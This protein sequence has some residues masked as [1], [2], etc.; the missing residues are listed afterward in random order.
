MNSPKKYVPQSIMVVFLLIMMAV[1]YSINIPIAGL[2]NDSLVRL[3]MNGFLALS[4]LPMLNVGAGINF[5]MPIGITAGLL[6]M[7]LA[8]NLSLTGLQGFALAIFFSILVGIPFGYGYAKLLNGVKGKE[9]IA[10]LF[11]GFS[12]VFIMSFFWAVAPFSNPQMLWPIGGKGMR[13][14]IGLKNYFEKVLNKLWLVDIGNIHVPVGMFLFFLLVCFLIS[15]FFR[16]K[17]GL[18]MLA[19]GENKT[20]AKL[21]GLNIT[22]LRTLAIILS[23]TLAA[24][25]ICV[26]AQSYGFIELYEAPLMMAFPAA[27]AV[28]IGGSTGRRTS[29]LQ[30]VIGTYLFQSIYVVSG[31]LANQL[32]VPEV[33]EILR[34][35]VTNGIILYALIYEGG[36]A[37]YEKS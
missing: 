26:Y 21:S 6:G 35:I 22:G 1:A 5:G 2:F 9:E 18:A 25:G 36:R 11:A 19:V 29:I 24:V 28:L 8:V 30:V 13:P 32:L 15:L 12:F 17:V 31:P 34:M 7:C 20:F 3:F 16:T 37:R 23:T 14:T 27:S 10:G 4:L 33:S